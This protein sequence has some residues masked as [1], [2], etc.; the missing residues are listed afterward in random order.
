MI[1]KSLNIIRVL[2]SNCTHEA[3][4]VVIGLVRRLG[5]SQE[6]IDRGPVYSTLDIVAEPCYW[7]AHEA[8][9]SCT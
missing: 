2:A 5:R 8:V 6:L 9:L 1:Y 4:V 3:F 7:I